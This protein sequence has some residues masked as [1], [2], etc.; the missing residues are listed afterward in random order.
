MKKL[1]LSCFFAAIMGAGSVMAQNPH[2][3]S[4]PTITDNGFTLT[5]TGSIAGLG[6]NQLI[7]ISLSATATITTTCTNAGGNVAPGQIKTETVSATG[8]FRSGKNGRV[9]FTLT[10]PLPTPGE[11]PNDNW[12]GAI[13]DVVFSNVS[14]SVDGQVVYVNGQEVCP[15]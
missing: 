13:T 8:E 9:N 1:I 11:C 12:T 3:V 14:I 7:V 15:K 6:N 5:A 2:F 4:G 10:T